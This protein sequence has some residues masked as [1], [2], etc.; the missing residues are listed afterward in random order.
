MEAFTNEEK[1]SVLEKLVKGMCNLTDIKDQNIV[2]D[3]LVPNGI[4]KVWGRHT[5]YDCELTEKGRAL[6]KK[7]G[8][9][10][11]QSEEN[12][13]R[14]LEQLKEENVLLTNKKLKYERH[15]R[16]IAIASL[17][18]SII[19]VIVAIYSCFI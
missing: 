12:R 13:Q 19:S 18:V 14:K 9:N 2:D 3:C 17:V 15:T 10:R 6:L 4:V 1:Q 16:W 11:I 8:Y 7:G 5:G